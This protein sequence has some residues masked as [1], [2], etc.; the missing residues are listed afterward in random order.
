MTV[1][2][3][4]AEVKKLLEKKDQDLEEMK[5]RLKNQEKER[6]SELLKIQMEVN[7]EIC[8]LLCFC[9]IPLW[10]MADLHQV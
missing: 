7:E 6:Q 8:L 1:E 10:I 5:K 4:D 2:A 3:K 9:L